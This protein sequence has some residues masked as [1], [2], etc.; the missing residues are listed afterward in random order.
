MALRW[1]DGFNGYRQLLGDD[2]GGALRERYRFTTGGGYWSASGGT[3]Y[4]GQGAL[5]YSN[6]FGFSGVGRIL[7]RFDQQPTWIAGF[8][9]KILDIGNTS[10]SPIFGFVDS[11]T[12]QV[13]LS[14]KQD[15]RLTVTRDFGAGSVELGRGSTPLRS[16]LWNFVE[17]KSTIGTA[18]F[19]ELR[20]NGATEIASIGV[21]TN[22]SANQFADG[23]AFLA[24]NTLLLVGICDIDDFYL[25]DG[26]G[27]RFN[28]FLGPVRVISN[29]GT[30]NGATISF[31]PSTGSDNLSMINETI[32]DSDRTFNVSTVAGADDLFS[33]GGLTG[34]GSVQIL[35]VQHSILAK[36]N[37][38][39]FAGNQIANLCYQN[40]TTNVGTAFTL[41][42]SYMYYSQ[43]YELNPVTG[44]SF[45]PTEVAS[46]QWGY[47]CIA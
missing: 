37:S 39:A 20:I 16:T 21:K 3:G 10:I 38:P 4:D 35:A 11:I 43:L 44:T 5:R 36:T 33:Y 34:V 1:Y 28:D 47:R 17:L 7:Q 31:L 14:V 18:G 6:R 19:I 23:F 12:T 8:N 46:I 42:A 27:T 26:T 13:G 24:L 45:S 29:Y 30:G 32:P 2:F 25:C 22:N 15:A 40:A 41:T 9:L